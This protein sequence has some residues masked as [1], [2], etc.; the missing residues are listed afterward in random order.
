LFGF[1][2]AQVRDEVVEAT[3]L[4]RH[5]VGGGECWLWRCSRGD[6]GGGDGGGHKLC[7]SYRALD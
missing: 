6:G 1:R 2:V 5:G 3:G 4:G 7:T